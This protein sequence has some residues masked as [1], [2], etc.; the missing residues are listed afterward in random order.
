[1]KHLMIRQEWWYDR[2]NL[3]ENGRIAYNIQRWVVRP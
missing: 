1:M 2:R 3:E